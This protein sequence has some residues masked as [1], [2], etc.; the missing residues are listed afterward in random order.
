M[1]VNVAELLSMPLIPS[2]SLDLY[3]LQPEYVVGLITVM[4]I[5]STVAVSVLSRV[6]VLSS[7][8]TVC[9]LATGFSVSCWL[10]H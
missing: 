2:P 3:S 8:G 9:S 10:C 1:V 7:P 5:I 4:Y 6:N